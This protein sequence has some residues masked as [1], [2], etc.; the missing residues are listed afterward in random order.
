MRFIGFERAGWK[1]DGAN[2]RAMTVLLDDK[3]FFVA[4]AYDDDGISS[5]AHVVVDD[6]TI[7]CPNA[8]V[9]NTK[10]WIVVND[11]G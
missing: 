4:F 7:R 10:I 9:Q 11:R 6:L 3:Q 2:T 1:F 5:I 8:I